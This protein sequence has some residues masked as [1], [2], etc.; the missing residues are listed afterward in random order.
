[1]CVQDDRACHRCLKDDAPGDAECGVEVVGA[2]GKDD[3]ADGGVGECAGQA[4]ASAHRGLQLT[5]VAGHRELQTSVQPG[6]VA[7]LGAG[8]HGAPCKE[9]EGTVHA[10]LSKPM[11]SRARRL[12]EA[13]V[14]CHERWGEQDGN[15]HGFHFVGPGSL[16]KA[17]SA[18][19]SNLGDEMTLAAYGGAARRLAAPVAPCGAAARRDFVERTCARIISLE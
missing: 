4:S 13:T 3:A 1:L 10:L 14:P 9:C 2:G 8:Q 5:A 6:N 11:W 19:T 7:G 17:P 15:A 12:G 18:K 16:T